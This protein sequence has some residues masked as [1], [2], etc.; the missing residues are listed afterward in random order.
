MSM[1][2]Q[3]GM[4]QLLAW[5]H[6][7]YLPPR[8]RSL[9]NFME[10]GVLPQ[11][12]PFPQFD[13]NFGHQL[14]KQFNNGRISYIWILYLSNVSGEIFLSR[15]KKYFRL[16]TDEISAD[17]GIWCIEISIWEGNWSSATFSVRYFSKSG[18]NSIWKRQRQSCTWSACHRKSLQFFLCSIWYQYIYSVHMDAKVGPPFAGSR[19]DL[20][21]RIV[22]RGT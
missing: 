18:A 6:L 21:V 9:L 20:K 7:H 1:E 10:I 13:V 19:N 2:C 16:K 14:L 8:C 4:W 22:G 12:P 5:I 15:G 17:H 3:C 11:K